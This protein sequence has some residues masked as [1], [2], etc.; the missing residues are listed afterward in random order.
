MSHIKQFTNQRGVSLLFIILISSVILS[1]GAGVSVIIIQEVKIIEQVGDSVVSFYAADSGVEEQLFD[2]YKALPAG[3]SPQHSGNVAITTGGV[4]SYVVNAK[5][6]VNTAPE[7]CFMANGFTIDAD[8]LALNYCIKSIGN[9]KNTK[10]AIE[11]K[12]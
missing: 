7:D 6:S 3:H 4:A 9:F 8:C 2:L 5:C 11:I 10:R 12:Y 1:I